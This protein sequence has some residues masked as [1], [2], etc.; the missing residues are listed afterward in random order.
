MFSY[1]MA[2]EAKRY[3]LYHK[4]ISQN[5]IGHLKRVKLLSIFSSN[6]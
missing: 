4:P 6:T 3:L 2:L 5:H 1:V